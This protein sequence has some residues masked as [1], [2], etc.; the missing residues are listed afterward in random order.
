MRRVLRSEGGWRWRP[1]AGVR[2][3]PEERVSRADPD[4]R[5]YEE[6]GREDRRTERQER[7]PVSDERAPHMTKVPNAARMAVSAPPMFL[8]VI[9]PP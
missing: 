4:D 1:R 2:V 7:M 6:Q 8:V 3:D 5:R 9:A